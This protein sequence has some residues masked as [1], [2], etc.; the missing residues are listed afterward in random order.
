MT[1]RFS[2]WDPNC[3]VTGSLKNVLQSFRVKLDKLGFDHEAAQRAYTRGRVKP[4][5]WIDWLMK[6]S[7]DLIEYNAR[8]ATALAELVT[9]LEGIF[10]TEAG[11]LAYSQWPCLC[12]SEEHSSDRSR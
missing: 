3:F 7:E 11:V 12:R 6:M 9:I 10:L 8:D 4:D 5:L 2:V 1:T